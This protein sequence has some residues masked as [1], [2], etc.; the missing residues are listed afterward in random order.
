MYPKTC[1]FK[2]VKLHAVPDLSLGLS[3]LKSP[4]PSTVHSLLEA[5]PVFPGTDVMVRCLKLLKEFRRKI[6]DD[7]DQDDDEDEEVISKAVPPVDIVYERDMLTQTY[8]LSKPCSH[9][10]LC[11]VPEHWRQKCFARVSRG[12]CS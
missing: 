9:T 3:L 4:S 10:C 5:A 1:G 6:E 12:L 8:E 11:A 2:S 7:H